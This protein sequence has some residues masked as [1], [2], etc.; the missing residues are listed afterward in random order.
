M[1]WRAYSRV[2]RSSRVCPSCRYTTSLLLLFGGYCQGISL[3]L[4]ESVS[5]LGVPVGVQARQQAA[6][7]VER[8][9]LFSED[10]LVSTDQAGRRVVL[11]SLARASSEAPFACDTGIAVLRK[12]IEA[13]DSEV[14]RAVVY[15]AG[16]GALCANQEN[17]PPL[18]IPLQSVSVFTEALASAESAAEP[19]TLLCAI[20]EEAAQRNALPPS[21][22]A[23]SVV[24]FCTD[25]SMRRVMQRMLSQ[26]DFGGA[27]A[28]IRLAQLAFARGDSPQ[29]E[30]LERLMHVLEG[31]QRSADEGDWSA[32]KEYRGRLAQLDHN[33]M[34]DNASMARIDE[35]F[36]VS[37]LARRD[38]S[39]AARCIA[40][41]PFE[42]RT[43]GMHELVLAFIRLQNKQG[44][45]S[46]SL[47]IT[48]P[49]L[50]QYA[51]KDNE[52][53]AAYRD[54]QTA[55]ANT[56]SPAWRFRF[57]ILG[58]L[59]FGLWWMVLRWSLHRQ[60]IKT[61]ATR[62]DSQTRSSGEYEGLLA[63]FGLEP[64]ATTSEIKNAYR[65]NIKKLHPDVH[66]GGIAD[67]QD[68][69]E[70]TK[71]YKRLLYLQSDRGVGKE[72]D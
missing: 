44:I 60:R 9:T 32:W 29:Q 49:V 22:P 41:V 43:P 57:V 27:M 68:F 14:A 72:R 23:R 16:H 40:E 19:S 38:I 45:D 28:V 4:A 64:G 69:I 11:R 50:Q 7:G 61:Q 6:P 52:I 55:L 37:V 54:L 65:R 39:A 66:R 2:H 21:Q 3:S 63:V 48:A 70:L 34:I 58:V 59:L 42:L 1:C 30:S 31:L 26:S 24:D 25:W 33:R 10:F 12:A 56:A 53:S 36:L 46:E 35:R 18:D 67:R 5:Y 47:R 51:G 62:V 17:S 8:I 20:Y 13:G 15:A 71:Q